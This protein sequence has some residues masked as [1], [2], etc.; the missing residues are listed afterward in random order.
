MTGKGSAE[1]ERFKNGEELTKSQSIRAYCALCM[2]NFTD[3]RVDCEGYD[4]PLHPFMFYNPSKR[5]STR[6]GP[7]NPTW[8]RKE[9]IENEIEEEEDEDEPEE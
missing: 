7:K 3:G 6:S 2:C 5:K 4:C 8:L 9:K 1:L